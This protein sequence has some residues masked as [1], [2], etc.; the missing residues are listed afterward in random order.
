[1]SGESFL[2]KVRLEELYPEWS[3]EVDRRISASEIRIKF[4][5]VGGALVNFIVAAGAAIPMIFYMGQISSNIAQSSADL[6]AQTLRIDTNAEW[7][8]DRMVWEA[9]VESALEKRGVLVERIER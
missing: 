4:W 3:Q 5:V 1:V 6:K 8:R 9:R 7:V 2:P